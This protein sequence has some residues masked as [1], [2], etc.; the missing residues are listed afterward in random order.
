MKRFIQKENKAPLHHFTV[1]LARQ[2]IRQDVFLPLVVNYVARK[3]E[4]VAE[5]GPVKLMALNSER[6]RPDLEVLSQHDELGLYILPSDVQ[7]TI[8]SLW[9]SPVR[10]FTAE[11]PDAYVK[12]EEPEIQHA[13]AQLQT[14]LEK[15]LRLLHI[16]TG[17][18]VMTSCSVWY[19]QDQD[20]AAVGAKARVPFVTLHK[21]CNFDPV[22]FDA[23]VK[24]FSGRGLKNQAAKVIVFNQY[25]KDFMRE[26]DI[27][28][29]DEVEISG[30]L[31]L[32][33][34]HARKDKQKPAK[35][36]VTLFSFH[37]CSGQMTIPEAEYFFLKE[38]GQGFYHYFDIVHGK[39]AQLAAENPDIEVWVK[40]KWMDHWAD[41]VEL[42]AQRMG[43]DVADLP[44]FHI[45]IEKSAQELIEESQVIIGFNS[46]TMLEAKLM[47]KPIVAPL[48]AE[49]TEKYYDTHVYFHD[50]MDEAFNVV[51]DVEEFL[52]E[53][54][55]EIAGE[56]PQKNIPERMVKNYLGFFDGQ[57][58]DRIVNIFKQEIVKAA[59]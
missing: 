25:A 37:H 22:V 30:I 17:I 59:S 53:I 16:K 26:T 5:G 46:T 45:S 29:E 35:K 9:L 36:Q 18:N 4:C 8:N 15:F 20:W 32:D 44:N 57:T 42:A 43:Y 47:G 49:A 34:I 13:R 39:M 7:T 51:K 12:N 3:L 52:P 40:P 31:R 55:A 58:A 38:P 33:A 28:P 1:Q 14:Y 50:D 27:A 21:E 19:Q 11:D 24:R 54:L 48:F 23:A 41:K 2:I 56:R 10:G 6:Y